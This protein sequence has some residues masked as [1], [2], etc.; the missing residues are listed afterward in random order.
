MYSRWF[1]WRRSES[2]A[3]ND[4]T[5]A[6]AAVLLIVFVSGCTSIPQQAGFADVENRIDERTGLRVTMEQPPAEG[7]VREAVRTLLNS[8]LTMAVA[9]QVALFNNHRLRAVYSEAWPRQRSSR[10]ACLA[11]RSSMLPRSE[12]PASGETSSTL[13]LSSTFSTSFT[14]PCAAGW[15][16]QSSKRPSWPSLPPPWIWRSTPELLS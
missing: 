12:E 11:T 7:R 14:S 10:S 2:M 16:H 6:S 4:R 3:P 9:Q 5:T 8:T 13:P 15:P 1:R